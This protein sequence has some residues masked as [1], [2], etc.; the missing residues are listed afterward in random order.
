VR[1]YN[2]GDLGIGREMHCRQTTGLIAG[3]LACYVRN[4]GELGG[5]PDHALDLVDAGDAPLATVA[6]VYEPPLEAPNAVRFMVYSPGGAL[7][8]EAQLDTQGDNKSVPQS[9]LNCHGGRSSY[10]P[11]QHAVTGARFL[12]FD[13]G[14]FEFS[15]VPELTLEAQQR[16][17]AALNQMI[18]ATSPTP[19]ML[20]VIDGMFSSSVAHDPGF[21]PA[22]WRDS[23]RDTRLYREVIAPYCRSCHNTFDKGQHDPA[24]FATAA[25]LRAKANGVA[26]R[27]CTADSRGMP[28]AEATAAGFFRS[29][30]RGLL[31]TWLDA[32]GAC[33]H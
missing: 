13:P 3:G 29:G 14:A 24:A 27:I 2:Q 8:T 4:F 11:Q 12:A 1:Y 10:E 19:A 18:A 22:G 26:Y 25:D 16:D 9:C 20:E 7:V 6:M 33:A 15:K 28:T 31:L 23:P 30:A 17:F 5:D 21:V 32:P